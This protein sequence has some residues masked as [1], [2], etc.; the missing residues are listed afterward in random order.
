MDEWMTWHITKVPSGVMVYHVWV[1]VTNPPAHNHS[2]STS[3]RGPN[4]S[5]LAT[6]AAT[7]WKLGS[8]GS[9]VL[10]DDC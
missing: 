1:S 2:V 3:S 5:V 10:A 4:R 6:L 7:G 9:D 8:E